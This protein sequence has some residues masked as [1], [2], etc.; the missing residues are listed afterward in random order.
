MFL[1]RWPDGYQVGLEPEE[2]DEESGV[3]EE[4]APKPKKTAS[5]PSKPVNPKPKA[6][7]TK[8]VPVS[9]GGRSV[10]TENYNHSCYE[11]MPVGV[12]VHVMID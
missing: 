11:E 8:R 6:S 9:E 5:K 10:A 3:S 1:L 4:P 12:S 2:D 7:K